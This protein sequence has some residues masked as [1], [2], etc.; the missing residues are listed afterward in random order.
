MNLREDRSIDANETD[1][2]REDGERRGD[3]RP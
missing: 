2:A 3:V 1:I